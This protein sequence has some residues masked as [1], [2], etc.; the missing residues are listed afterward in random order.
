MNKISY[1]PVILE[2]PFAP[3]TKGTLEQH[4]KYLRDCMHDCLVNHEDAPFASHALYT[5]PLDDTKPDERRIG[6]D[7][8]LTWGQFADACVVYYDYGI[9]DGMRE[10]IANAEKNGIPIEMRR[11]PFFYKD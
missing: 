3:S 8:G 2:T 9:S 5:I 11:L 10:G 7:A 1:R 4:K 6:I